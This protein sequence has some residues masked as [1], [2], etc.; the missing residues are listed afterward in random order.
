MKQK[1]VGLCLIIIALAA[2]QPNYT[3]TSKVANSSN[4]VS[5]AIEPDPEISKIIAPFKAKLDD[6][7]NEV[8]GESA[9]D[10]TRGFENGEALLGNFCADLLYVQ[11][12][13]YGGADLSVVTIGGLRVPIGKGDVNVGLVYELMPFDNEFVII[14]IDGESVEK[15]IYRL[16]TK[17]NTSLGNVK[18]TFRRDKLVSATIGGEKFDKNKSYRLAVSDYLANGGD[19]MD[20]LKNHTKMTF[21]KVKVRDAI[22]NHFHDLTKAGKKATARLGTSVTYE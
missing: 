1:L 20:Y 13:K 8:I 4:G 5:D 12:K 22:L 7:M 10:L 14:T 11:A 6:Q 21:T 9:I 15:L 2:C 17:D 18:A 19:Y 16:K 3:Y